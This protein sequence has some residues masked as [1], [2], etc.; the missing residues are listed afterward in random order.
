MKETKTK[1]LT[2]TTTE[3]A[4]A[5][6]TEA[7]PYDLLEPVEEKVIRMHYGLSESDEKAL[8]YAVG[9]SEDSRRRVSLI[10]A[11]NIAELDAEVPVVEG[12][13]RQVLREYVKG[14]DLDI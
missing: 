5:K 6:K 3:V 4:P 12:A 11:V 14:L 8:E 10:E 13:D 2:R 1:K 7:A 9:A